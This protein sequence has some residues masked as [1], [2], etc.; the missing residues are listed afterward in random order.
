MSRRVVRAVAARGTIQDAVTGVVPTAESVSPPAGL[1][2]IR[3]GDQGYPTTNDL[4]SMHEKAREDIAARKELGVQRYGVA[5]QPANG[6]DAIRDWYEEACDGL[7]YGAQVV[8][9][10]DNPH[11]TYVGRLIYALSDGGGPVDFS[12]VFVPQAVLAYL[13]TNHVEW[14]GAQ[15]EA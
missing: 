14:Y 12:N 11:E 6:R 3:P 13:K 7:I 1:R 10:Q 5:L 8:W 9:E 15:E 4:P 2:P